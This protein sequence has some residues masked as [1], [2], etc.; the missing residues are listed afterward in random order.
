MSLTRPT[1]CLGVRIAEELRS[2]PT[3]RS[4]SRSR[5]LTRSRKASGEIGARSLLPGDVPRN[6][7]DAPPG[8]VFGGRHCRSGRDGE[9]D[10]A[11][12]GD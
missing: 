10:C 3:S 9:D 11:G 2:A 4:I 7:L 6:I 1:I 5:L 8:I 12:D